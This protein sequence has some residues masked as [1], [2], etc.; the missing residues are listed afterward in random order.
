MQSSRKIF[1]IVK[2]PILILV[3]IPVLAFI[4]GSYSYANT[5]DLTRTQLLHKATNKTDKSISVLV[6]FSKNRTNSK[7]VDGRT[8]SFLEQRNAFLGKRAIAD[9]YRVRTFQRSSLMAMKVDQQE[10]LELLDDPALIVMEDGLKRPSLQQS[11]KSIYP[12]AG[13]SPFHGNNQWAVAILDTGINKNHSFLAGK[14]VSEACYSN[15]GAQPTTSS[16]CPGGV[17]ASTAVGS[18]VQCTLSGCS[19]GTQVAGI[20]AGLGSSFTGVAKDAK[21]ISIQVF[22]RFD[23]ESFCFPQASCL[24]AYT[25][26]IIAGLERVYE[27]RNSF[28]IA[29]VNLSL[30]SDE[31]ISGSCDDQPE[32]PI[33]DLL[34][35]A[36]I[37]VIAATGNNGGTTT[38]QSPAC[39]SSAFAVASTLDISNATP[40]SNNISGQLDLFAPGVNITSSNSS[41]G[42]SIGSGTSF[43][44]P[45][46][47]GAWAA[48]KHANPSLS[49]AAISNL[50]KTTGPVIT[51]SS[52]ARRRLDLTAILEKIAPGSQFLPTP[53]LPAIFLL[54]LDE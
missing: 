25:S 3:C 28:S 50:M 23:D 54:L 31:L 34:S 42:F 33:I 26:D 17:M 46:V 27:L 36:G 21:L 14:V 49:V 48:I 47:A 6:R 41:G 45:H 15:G 18:G 51:Q 4:S 39:I 8:A 22:S 32:K 2:K 38:M 35:N 19:H 13:V 53:F 7:L 10:L 30:G 11:V 29:A 1:A 44:A 52:V 16:L 12:S 20:A 37:A 40:S 24:G 5:S 9:S 43:A